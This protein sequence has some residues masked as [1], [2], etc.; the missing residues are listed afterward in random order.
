M[1]QSNFRVARSLHQPQEALSHPFKLLVV[2]DDLWF[3][4]VF[5]HPFSLPHAFPLVGSHFLGYSNQPYFP[6]L[7]RS[8]LKITCKTP[9]FPTRLSFQHEQNERLSFSWRQVQCSV[10]NLLCNVNKT[11]AR[12]SPGGKSS[13]QPAVE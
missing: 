9:A 7:G 12:L 1:K 4:T 3:G 6:M 2:P 13:A 5:L 11:H 10:H 8:L